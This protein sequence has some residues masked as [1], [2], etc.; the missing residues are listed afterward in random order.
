MATSKLILLNFR[1]KRS[2]SHTCNKDTRKPESILEYTQQ[3]N[4]KLGILTGA[5]CSGNDCTNN[6]SLYIWMKILQKSKCSISRFNKD[7]E[8]KKKQKKNV[9]WYQLYYRREI[10]KT[11]FV[12]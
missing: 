9:I 1:R 11:Q 2:L 4:K 10:L 7:T 5:R 6:L 12:I 8:R 3:K